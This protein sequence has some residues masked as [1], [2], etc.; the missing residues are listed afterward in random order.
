MNKKVEQGTDWVN[1][2]KNTLEKL[3]KPIDFL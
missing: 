3:N 2:V 1:V